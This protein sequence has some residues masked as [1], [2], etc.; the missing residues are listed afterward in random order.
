LASFEKA[1]QAENLINRPCCAVAHGSADLELVLPMHCRALGVQ[2]PKVLETYVDLRLSTQR[3]VAST[4][5][6]GMRASTLKQICEALGVEMI[7]SEHCGLDDAWMVLLA[8][9]QLLLKA[10]ADLKPVDFVEE[11]RAFMDGRNQDTRLC[12]DGL[13]W[14]AVS[15]DLHAWFDVHLGQAALSPER[16]SVVLG[17]DNKPSGRAVAHFVDHQAAA[18]ALQAFAGGKLLT[19][20]DAAQGSYSE[21]LI[22]VRPLRRDELQLPVW[23]SLPAPGSELSGPSLAPFPLSEKE[24]KR[25]AGTG[26][27]FD[28]Q[29]GLC[30]RGES[31]RYL[32][33]TFAGCIRKPCFDFQQGN[34]AREVCPYLHSSAPRSVGICHAFRKGHCKFGE[35]CRYLHSLSS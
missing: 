13:P 3:Y 7:G 27:C 32:H 17:M 19:C 2:M 10:G 14:S 9:Q 1:M 28:F 33:E 34:C 6:K 11:Q 35:S 5:T 26:F 24:L 12:L 31:C 15:S 21:R 25:S 18:D 8:T 16:L 22:L 20:G 4:G 30:T 29:K 23:D